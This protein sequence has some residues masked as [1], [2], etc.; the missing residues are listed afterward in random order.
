MFYDMVGGGGGGRA[1]GA[2]EL[3]LPLAPQMTLLRS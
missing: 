2:G 3:C 1:S